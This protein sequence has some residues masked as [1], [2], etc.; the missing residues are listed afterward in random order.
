MIGGIPPGFPVLQLL[1]DVRAIDGHVG[2]EGAVDDRSRCAAQVAVGVA[3]RDAL[4]PQD[5]AAGRDGR[6]VPHPLQD[7]AVLDRSNVRVR[8][9]A[10]SGEG[11]GFVLV[12]VIDMAADIAVWQVVVSFLL[13][14]LL[15]LFLAVGG[16]VAAQASKSR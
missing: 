6:N 3:V 8:A 7:T 5:G 13:L 2:Q 16:R 14:L 9:D 4:V 10:G 12:V 1:P 11:D 15:F